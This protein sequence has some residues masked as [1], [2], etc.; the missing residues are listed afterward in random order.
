MLNH[1]DPQVLYKIRTY[2]GFGKV[3]PFPLKCTTLQY[4]RYIVMD[5]N[6]ITRLLY[7]FRNRFI[8]NTS[9]TNLYDSVICYHLWGPGLRSWLPRS[10]PDPIPRANVSTSKAEGSDPLGP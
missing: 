2:L 9:R 6:G 8:L 3:K 4:Y 1:Y 10:L 7:L 5:F